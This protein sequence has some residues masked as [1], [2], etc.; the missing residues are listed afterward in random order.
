MERLEE[1]VGVRVGDV[2]LES[3]VPGRVVEA[4]VEVLDTYTPIATEREEAK[5]ILSANDESLAKKRSESAP[6]LLYLIS[7]LRY[8]FNALATSSSTVTSNFSFPPPLL[9][10]SLLN[11][12]SLT[13]LL[14]PFFFD[15]PATRCRVPLSSR[16][17]CAYPTKST[18][19]TEERTEGGT[20]PWGLKNG[21]EEEGQYV[22][23]GRFDRRGVS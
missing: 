15:G 12:G 19:R 2:R 3:R 4:E 23:E 14:F 5:G 17:V 20:G 1:G 21:E 7:T 9:S 18:W 13:L 10:R 6:N 16:G 11:L 22:D 8:L